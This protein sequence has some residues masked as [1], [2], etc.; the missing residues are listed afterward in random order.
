MIEVV[1]PQCAIYRLDDSAAGNNASTL[2]SLDSWFA[3]FGN[4]FDGYKRFVSGSRAEGVALEADW[5]HPSADEDVMNLYAGWLGVFV[6]EYHRKRGPSSSL[7]FRLEGCPPCYCKLEITSLRRLRWAWNW[8]DESC[9]ERSGG[10]KWLNTLNVLNKL[11]GGGD[12]SGPAKCCGLMDW[13]PGLVCSGPHPEMQREFRHRPR[14]WPSTKL[15]NSIMKCPMLLVLVGHKLSPESRLQARLSWSLCELLLMRDVP[16]KAKQGYI[17]YKYVMKRFLADKR[18]SNESGM[19]RSYVSGYHFKT[20][21]L[22]FL[23]KRTPQKI[24][25]PFELFL[26]L[27][28]ELYE[29]LKVGKLPHYFLPG[30]NLLETVDKEEQCIARQTI[31]AILSDPLASIFTSTTL[32]WQIYG[33]I[34]PIDLVTRFY[35]VFNDP[36]CEESCEDMFGN[37]ASLDGTR[38]QR[39]NSQ[40]DMDRSLTVTGRPE[41]I[42]LVDVMRR[43]IQN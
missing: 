9:I 35:H 11:S 7:T 22:Y 32:P 37:L 36:N 6:P 39:Y 17:A 19:G 18:C 43:I 27:L 12:I 25:S 1:F 24:T 42:V 29:Y 2:S 20:S 26:D 23:E 16:E 10:R 4:W 3:F 33:G 15:I 31:S 34:I 41:I 8:L 5:G 40:R 30:C 14:N 21:F 28:K 13:V 38:Q